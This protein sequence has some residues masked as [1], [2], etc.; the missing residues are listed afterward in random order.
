MFAVFID[1]VSPRIHFILEELFSRR[2][3]TDLLVYTSFELFETDK[4]PYK[5]CY[6]E[7]TEAI[8]PYF[9]VERNGFMT[10][11]VVNPY[12]DPEI[13]SY[14]LNEK[15]KKHLLYN[16]SNFSEDS[17]DKK[18]LENHINAP[19]PCLFPNLGDLGFDVFGMSFYFLSRYEEYQK[20]DSDSHG[21]FTFRNSIQSKWNYP[22]IPCVDVA[23]FYFLCQIGAAHL[24]PSMEVIP[25]FDIDISF[26]FKGRS[27]RRQLA[28]TLK[29]PKH[30]L[31]RIAVYLGSKDP[32][33]PQATVFDFLQKNHI[34]NACIFWLCSRRVKGVNRQVSRRFKLFQER[35]QASLAFAEIGIHPSFTSRPEIVWEEEKIW[36]EQQINRPVIHSRQHF[37]HLLF[38]ETY[39]TL[40]SLNIQNDWSM[41]FAESAGFRAGTA[42]SFHW[43]DLFENKGTDLCI[44]P[45]CLMDVTAKNY[46]HLNTKDAIDLGKSLKEIVFLFGG[47]FIF[48]AH[49]ESLSETE[50][51]E[52]WTPVFESWSQKL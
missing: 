36:L 37:V 29:Y 11:N 49:N 51:W 16:I 19:Y 43:F 45:F 42:Y 48:I 35:V 21:R 15:A 50:G 34:K 18:T 7:K 24:I 26:R 38:P 1:Q 40:L 23:F 12:F 30:L 25:S 41:G 14:H 20:F 28:S 5:I 9:V 52:A 4:S 6:V 33:D 8:Y 44:H 32:F 10:E 31:S 22:S 27:L 13:G 17:L 3:K 39:R 2:L 47:N 46:L